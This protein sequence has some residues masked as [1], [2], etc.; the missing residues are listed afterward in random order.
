MAGD[1]RWLLPEGVEEILPEKAAAIESLRRRLL[2]VMQRRGFR[3]VQPPLMEFLDSLLTGAGEDLDSQ[4]YKVSDHMSH[5]TLG[6]RADL[7]PQIARIDAHYLRDHDVNR[8]CY[9]GT[10]LRTRPKQP[11][12][13]RELLQLGA[14]MFGEADPRADCEIIETM[15]EVLGESGVAEITVGLGHVGIY[16]ELMLMAGLDE[17]PAREVFDAL[18][19]RSTPDMEALLAEYADKGLE[20]F[21]HLLEL[22]GDA[23]VL[24]EA[25][26]VLPGTPEISLALEQ[27]RTVVAS[28]ETLEIKP[29]IHIDLADLRGYRYHTGLTYQAFVPRQGR[30][31][32][33]GGRYDRIGEAFGRARAATGFS[34]NL[35]S[36]VEY[37]AFRDD[38]SVIL[39]PSDNDAGLRLKIDALRADGETV[40]TL[41][42]GEGRESF[43]G[44]ADRKLE[45]V[46]GEWRVVDL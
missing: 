23:G 35:K 39:A 5:R 25:A 24:E 10:V 22:Q 4:T 20:P 38:G 12:G 26:R 11:G 41:M 42:P 45:Q 37:Y 17:G 2:G 46:D 32:A 28:L 13:A 1:E 43:S 14:E 31:L 7:T 21:R 3:P 34:T 9:V 19:R 33:E 6:I 16:R 18:A 30:A 36:L 27:L 8:L 40:V 29:G 44:V 15:L